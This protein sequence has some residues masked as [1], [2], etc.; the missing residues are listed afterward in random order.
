V[1]SSAIAIRQSERKQAPVF[2]G[3]HAMKMMFLLAITTAL[4]IGFG[5][6]DSHAGELPRDAL[7][8]TV[9]PYL[10]LH[11]DDPVHWQQWN[12]DAL[13]LAEALGRPIFISSGYF[14]CHW[15]HVMQRES[16]HDPRVADVLNAHFVP[17]K[18]D[19]E[20][21][22][23]TDE[24]LIRFM[25]EQSGIAGWPLNVI[26]S[27]DARPLAG[28]LYEPPDTVLEKLSSIAND[29]PE[30]L[31]AKLVGEPG[32]RREGR[33]A[34]ASARAE[35][36]E[37][38]W[39]AAFA[40][41]F[42]DA[43]LAEADDLQGGFGDQARFPHPPRLRALLGFAG[44]YPWI[45][46]FL[47]LTL[48]A[49]AGK[50]LRDHVEGGFFRYTVD[51]DW[52]TPHFE[53]MLYDNAQLAELYL[54]AA[55][56]LDEPR[57]R[58]VALDT[59]DFMIAR[60]ARA[61]GGFMSAVSALDGDG[62]EGGDV[63]W[64]PAQLGRALPAEL[65]PL[66]ASRFGL[67]RPPTFEAGHLLIPRRTPEELAARLALPEDLV[68]GELARMQRILRETRMKSE[69]VR[70]DKA[71]IAWN[72]LAL[73][74][75]AHAA[76]L[77][78]RYLQAGESLAAFLKRH[79][80][81]AAGLPRAIDAAGNILGSGTLEDYAFVANGLL[82]WHRLTG[83][84]RSRDT[85]H[86]LF[87]AAWERFHDGDLWHLDRRPL[88]RYGEGQ[89]VIEDHFMPSPTST[90]L[91]IAYL[92]DENASS[93]GHGRRA[94]LTRALREGDFANALSHG[95]AISVLFGF[96]SVR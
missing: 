26:T 96:S 64:T 42:V 52:E 60:L 16:F 68:E 33:D 44:E 36:S 53:K 94:S 38:E 55:E 93:A 5:A 78:Q 6:K 54:L 69:V 62:K 4:S 95:A 22:I 63:L 20:V 21:D 27:P 81:D 3:R 39:V 59:L 92:L 35:L 58:E 37:A 14:A 56:V 24:L 12:E 71:V 77:D 66:A 90:L 65:V 83:D 48:D 13:A 25:R 88:L 84:Q 11:A 41:A 28:M 89:R 74:A 61:D 49:M 87:E 19:R 10:A 70:D 29:W 34:P 67:H 76:R 46:D 2:I 57:W 7:A 72:G 43:A 9:S 50:G 1:L 31:A 18:I 17:V 45:E 85:A 30:R 47:Q 91:A 32:E 23:A 51:P 86:Q 82:A 75:L 40:N 79:V 15:C 73:E 8:G 80:T